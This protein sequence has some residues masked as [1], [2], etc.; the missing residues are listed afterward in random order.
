MWTKVNSITVLVVDDENRDRAQVASALAAKGYSVLQAYCYSDA[1]AVFEMNRDA[2]TLL[3]SDVAL[4]DGNGCALALAMKKQKADLR[5]LFISFQ[6]GTEICKY[7]GLSVR[8]LHLLRKP[9]NGAKLLSR[10]RRV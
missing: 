3:I 10:V 2:V 6:V 7:Y 4:P 9:F 8:H 5:V 1:M